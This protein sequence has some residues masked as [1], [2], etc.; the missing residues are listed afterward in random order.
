MY[1]EHT[2]IFMS[3]SGTLP[4]VYSSNSEHICRNVYLLLA[5]LEGHNEFM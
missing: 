2:N 3:D 1:L 5:R 4:G